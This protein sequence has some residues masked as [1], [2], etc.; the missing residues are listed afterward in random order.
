MS[1]LHVTAYK[2]TLGLSKEMILIHFPNN[3]PCLIKNKIRQ[4]TLPGEEE[5]SSIFGEVK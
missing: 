1:L 4:L 2:T 3:L 5:S